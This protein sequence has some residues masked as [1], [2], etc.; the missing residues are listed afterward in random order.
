[1]I[2]PENM[3]NLSMYLLV[4]LMALSI[5][6]FSIPT[7]N[8]FPSASA[9]IYLDF[10]GQ[11]VTGT[12][13][14]GGGTINA[15]PSGHTDA[16]ITSMFHR[17][18]EDFR[19]FNVN[20]T[21]DESKY[22]AAP[23]SRRIRVIITPTNYFR[24]GVGGAAY[25]GSFTW[26]DDTPCFVFSNMLGNIK[27]IAECCTHETGHTLGLSHQS[28]YDNGCTMLQSYHEGVGSGET[29]WAP[30]MG[31]SYYR[32]MSGW[33]NGPT[34][35]GCNAAQDNLTII[36]QNNFGYRA[37]DHSNDVNVSPSVISVSNRTI[38]TGGIIT[39]S[40]DKD[41]F[42]LN[43]S[44]QSSVRMDF[45][46]FSL[47]NNTGANLDIKI[48]LL[49]SARQ[50]IRTYDPLQILHVTIDT[51]L[52]S[53]TY[54]FMVDGTG[55]TN[56]GDYG[57]LGE[58][59]IAGSVMPLSV[60]PIHNINLSGTSSNGKH[61]LNWNIISDERIKSVVIESSSNGTSFNN[62]SIVNTYSTR[63]AYTPFENND[64]YYRVKVTTLTNE[65][66]Y[67]NVLM[68]RGTGKK[69]EFIVSTLV[70]NELK[71]NAPAAY[72]FQMYDVN[73]RIISKGTRSSGLN[74]EN[75][76]FLANGM[77][78]LQ[79]M[80]NGQKMTERIVKQ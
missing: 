63:Y 43:V 35:S 41:Y 49:N 48:S 57:S 39:T 56:V 31:N 77:Y 80:S 17:V 44:S 21:T 46:P 33:N 16:E 53:G 3:K 71:I 50:V 65:T 18:A 47:G 14:N 12:I 75:T 45:K 4:L 78:V 64:L 15:A 42:A 40:T 25:T 70:H 51:V 60:T 9:T 62:L 61:S 69:K 79:I 34:P 28:K 58:Y 72:E 6:G 38:N 22:L 55:N 52:L 26:G 66:A 2:N 10:D 24:T 11:V 27:W 32:N 74:T 19:P 7:L 5:S 1:V 20:V 8:S 67:S 54:Y 73:G 68:L 76:A 30:V 29:S 23:I 13:W 37:D 36:T 59:S